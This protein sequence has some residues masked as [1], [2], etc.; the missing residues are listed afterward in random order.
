MI[1][2]LKREERNIMKGSY[3]KSNGFS[4]VQVAV[5]GTAEGVIMK[6]DD[7]EEQKAFLLR[8]LS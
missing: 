1:D 2:G 4:F 6:N 3:W 5:A 8:F 7:D